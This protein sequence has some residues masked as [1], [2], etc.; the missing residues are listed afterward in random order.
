MNIETFLLCHNEAKLLPYA[1]RHYRQFSDVT[2]L[3]NNS[4]D[5]TSEIARGMGAFVWNI[6]TPNEIN[7]AWYLQAK[8]NCW[9]LSSADWV[10]VADADEFVYH[11]HLLELLE[12]TDATIIEPETWNMYCAKFPTTEGQIT[13]QVNKGLRSP[14]KKCCMFRP[15]AIS[16]INYLPGC[17]GCH[18][19]GITKKESLGIKLLHMRHL[20]VQYTVDRNK[21]LN[22]RLSEFN[23]SQGWSWH[24]AMPEN[25]LRKSVEN[26]I[27]GA[28]FAL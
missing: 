20:S 16:E 3:E 25:E 1:I 12:T 4:T 9:K 6:N 21:Y 27:R 22:S 7:N 8:N 26:G 23:K 10:I 11:P 19:V 5:N 17:H 18:P 2:I 14:D 13:E 24:Y 28:E 15:S